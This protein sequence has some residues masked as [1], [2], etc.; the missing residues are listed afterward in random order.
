MKFKA[1]AFD[2][3]G[4][5]VDSKIDFG[6]IYRELNIP[7]GSAILE[8]LDLLNEADR[9]HAESILHYYEQKGAEESLIIP[10]ALDF[11]LHLEAHEI[12]Y[13]VFTRNSRPTTM[14]SI[15]KHNLNI[16][17]LISR[18][19]ATPKPHPEGLQIIAKHLNVKNEELLFVGDYLFD[20]QAGLAAQVPT[21]LYLASAADFETEGAYFT[22]DHYEKL[23]SHCFR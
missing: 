16:P 23:K 20:L 21:A 15:E 6:S 2:L 14:K 3:D 11:L 1:Y 10:D 12:P 18:D 13:A 9:K 7:Y 17:F 8:Q 19:D 5:L 4:T 22:F